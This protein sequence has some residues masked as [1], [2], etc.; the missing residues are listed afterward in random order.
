MYSAE[1]LYATY[2]TNH[3]EMVP[4]LFA[5]TQGPMYAN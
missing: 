2:S 4:G 3:S 1:K 5:T